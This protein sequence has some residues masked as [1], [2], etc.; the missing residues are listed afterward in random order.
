MWL[1]VLL[2]HRESSHCCFGS[3]PNVLGSTP[4][5]IDSTRNYIG[6]APMSLG[7]FPI[8]FEVREHFPCHHE[9]SHREHPPWAKRGHTFTGPSP[10]ENP[11]CPR[12]NSPC[13]S[14]ANINIMQ[15]VWICSK[16]SKTQPGLVVCIISEICCCALGFQNFSNAWL[17][18]KT[19]TI[20]TTSVLTYSWDLSGSNLF[21]RVPFR[22]S[23]VV[24]FQKKQSLLDFAFL[25]C[26]QCWFW[27]CSRVER[28]APCISGGFSACGSFRKA[29]WRPSRKREKAH[30]SN[31]LSRPWHT[32]H[33]RENQLVCDICCFWGIPSK[34]RFPRLSSLLK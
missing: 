28:A 11:V 33:S 27:H 21:H 19:H 29:K 9:H 17:E 6:S 31:V 14:E 26:V 2:S 15:C 7:V 32:L 22:V 20:D 1:G 18:F 12:S 5:V 13:E 24:F 25:T 30:P 16:F 8:T 23:R 3:T 4:N 10:T 34:K